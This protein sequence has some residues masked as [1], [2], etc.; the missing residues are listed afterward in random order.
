MKINFKKFWI[1]LTLISGA[2]AV[3]VWACF[4]Q[5]V[6]VFCAGA[7]LMTASFKLYNKIKS[8]P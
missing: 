4:D 7:L 6:G 5:I 3:F 1:E 8:T 2:L